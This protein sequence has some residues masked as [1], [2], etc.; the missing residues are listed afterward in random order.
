MDRRVRRAKSG[1]TNRSC[2]FGRVQLTWELYQNDHTKVRI[3]SLQNPSQQHS[4]ERRWR[5]YRSVGQLFW[6]PLLR[7]SKFN[8]LQDGEPLPT[9]S[10]GKNP[11]PRCY[12]CWIYINPFVRFTDG[13]TRW[14][15]NF[16]SSYNPVDNYYYSPL[17]G[18][19]RNDFDQRI[20]LQ[21][22]SVDFLASSDYMNRPPMAPAYIFVFD[23][24]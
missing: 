6:R 16:C 19:V 8:F 3:H 13:G 5:T 21:Y 22:G 24:S 15:C 23:V 18:G 10:F 12:E 20:E 17:N 9:V 14:I 4:Q 1:R 11:I 2:F 7:K